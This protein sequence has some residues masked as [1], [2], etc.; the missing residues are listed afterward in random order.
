MNL[1]HSKYYKEIFLLR[2]MVNLAKRGQMTIFVIVAVVIVALILLFFVFRPQIGGIFGEEVN[3][4]VYLKD[5]LEPQVRPAVELLGKQGSYQDP[6]GLITYK[7]EKLKYLCYTD[8][9]YETCSVQ[10]PMTK[11]NFEKELNL[12]VKSKANI[13]VRN[14][15]SE[16]EKR[17]YQVASGGVESSIAIVPKKIIISY[18]APLTVTRND[19]ISK[20]QNFNIELDSEMYDLLFIASSVIEYETK[21]GD[22]A[23]ELYLQYYPDLRIEKIKLTD[24]TKIYKLSNVITEEEFNFASRSLAWPAGYGIVGK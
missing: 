23:S 24:G 16:Y 1:K 11:N 2:N 14:L 21:M 3:P 20:Y 7:G 4:S 18:N 6:Q 5:C 13:C 22:S 17:D 12:I 15:I 8:D 9:F 19:Q 10:Q